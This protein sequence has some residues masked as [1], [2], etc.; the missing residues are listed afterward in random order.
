MKK[1]KE[2]AAEAC[3]VL[4]NKS[5][6]QVNYLADYLDKFYSCNYY[7]FHAHNS[8]KSCFRIIET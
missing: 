7:M 6:N 2:L 4:T 3:G 5:D 8:N 1:M